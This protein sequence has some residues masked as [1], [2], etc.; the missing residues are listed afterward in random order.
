MDTDALDGDGFCDRY[1][2]DG[3]LPGKISLRALTTFALHAYFSCSDVDLIVSHGRTLQG[4]HEQF[5]NTVL[6][7]LS[8]YFRRLFY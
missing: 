7:S 6:T 2:T 8:K 5:T 4:K 3:Y 1:A